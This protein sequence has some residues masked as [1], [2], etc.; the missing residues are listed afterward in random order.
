MFNYVFRRQFC[1]EVSLSMQNLRRKLFEI[2][3]PLSIPMRL[4]ADC[5]QALFAFYAGLRHIAEP[6][7][8][9][10]LL[11]RGLISVSWCS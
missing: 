10:S 5:G 11:F 6:F 9:I 2:Y 4:S 7:I 8:K 1:F 3:M